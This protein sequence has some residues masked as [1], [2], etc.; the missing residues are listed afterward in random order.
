M[1]A[2]F[3]CVPMFGHFL[4]LTPVARAMVEAGH[5]VAFGTPIFFRHA[6]ESAGFR[7]VRAG[8]EAD[9]PELV[10]VA[11]KYMHELVFGGVRARRMVPDLLAL[12][13]TWRPD[14]FVRESREFGAMVAG[15]LL[16]IPHA[17]VQVN[18]V[19]GLQRETAKS[20][21]PLGHLRATL[22]L[23]ERPIA[24][25]IDQ[26][27]VLAPFPA[28]L[29]GADEPIAPTTH[30]FR[31]LPAE[32]AEEPLPTWI[33]QIGPRPLIYVSL[34]TVF[35]RTHGREIFSKLLAGLR[36]VEAEVVVTV[37]N[38]VAPAILGPQPPHIH[39]ERYLPLGALLPRCSLVVFHG[40]SGTLGHVV[41][42]G[43]PMA[44]L[45]LGADQ[46]RNAARCAELGV[47]RTLNQDQLAP[48][49]VREVVV[50][51]L[52]TP[53]YRET[54]RTLRDEFDRLPGPEIAVE[55]LERLGRDHA[56]IP[57]SHCA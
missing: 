14:V 13:E 43:L 55:L 3:T 5:D 9:D 36:D 26:Y 53:G 45:P 30:R 21:A 39:V 49:H 18:A 51:L 16:G 38:D 19:G 2:L 34:G 4:P 48:E 7:W 47:S 8:V 46:P 20:F 52:H 17:K 10:A 50:D 1:R 6:V 31:A 15:E 54:A 23:P 22:G 44:I 57:A 37:G 32:D 25:L 24:E 29:Q 41:A 56:P 28:S 11:A 35:N 42:N 27:L 33:D 40:G 12:A